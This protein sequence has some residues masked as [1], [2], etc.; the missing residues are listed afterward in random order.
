[1]SK[2]RVG[3]AAALL[4]ASAG[5]LNAGQSFLGGERL[6][7]LKCGR[8]HAAY[9][10]EKYSAEEWRTVLQE[11]GP[12]AGLTEEMERE[13]FQFLAGASAAPEKKAV[14]TSPIL[15]GYLYTEY[16]SSPDSV[17]TFDIHYLNVNLAGRIH[18]RVSYRAE[19][20]FEH[21]GGAKEPPFIEPT[22]TSGSAGTPPSGWG[23][24]SP[25]STVSTSS[26]ARWRTTSSTGLPFPARSA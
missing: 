9:A 19:F 26:T 13:I 16:F 3:L 2:T 18:E 7:R 8:C 21:G 17:D 1:M 20:E 15:A 10:R 22:W 12:L 14:L 4:L 5:F 11:M 25:L 24:C 6:Y 23:R